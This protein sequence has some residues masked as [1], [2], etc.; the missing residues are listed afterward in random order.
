MDP[1]I[2]MLLMIAVP[3]GI[4]G[5]RLAIHHILGRMKGSLKMSL[6]QQSANS[7]EPFSG[8]LDLYTKKPIHADRLSVSLIGERFVPSVVRKRRMSD[9]W[10]EIYRLEIDI[11]EGERLFVGQQQSLEF[12]IAAPFVEQVQAHVDA[13]LRAVAA[14]MEEGPAKDA[15]SGP[16]HGAME[17]A[18]SPDNEKRWMVLA[19]LK[20][21]GVDLIDFKKVQVNLASM[22]EQ[23]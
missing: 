13:E 21:E 10:F 20:T 7:G 18:T 12:S 3:T 19:R 16:N 2:I 9:C 11:L 22:P 6:V 4:V 15:L 8:R 14:T 17:K 1:D 23:G 5:I